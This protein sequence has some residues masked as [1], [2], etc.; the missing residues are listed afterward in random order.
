MILRCLL[1][2]LLL[3]I[4]LSVFAD[5]AI[6]IQIEIRDHL[7]YPAEIKIAEDTKVKLLFIN[8]DSTAE[9]IESDELNREKIIPGNSQGAIFIGP[10]KKGEYSFFG[11]FF[12][13]TAQGKVIVE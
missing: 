11:E 4:K 8:H 6:E 2:I 5:P 12:H 3:G 10:L 13:K 1:F 7:F 9:E